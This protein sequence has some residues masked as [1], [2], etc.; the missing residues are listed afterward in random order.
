MFDVD[1]QGYNA[2]FSNDIS[3]LST[4]PDF[5]NQKGSLRKTGAGALTLSG[6]NTYQ[7]TTTVDGGTLRI[8]GTQ[9]TGDHIVNAGVLRVD[10]KIA[11]GVMTTVNTQG[12]LEGTGTT[13]SVLNKGTVAPGNSIG[14]LTV[15]G[16]YTATPGSTLAIEVDNNNRVD[17]LHVTG[18]TTFQS[19]AVVALQGEVF[20]QGIAYDFLEAG[21]TVAN[22]GLVFDSSL[23]F[24]TPRA[25]A[26]A[27]GLSFNVQRNS[28]AF[29]DFTSGHNQTAVANALDRLS[30]QPATG[31]ST[32]YDELLNGQ[33]TGFGAKMD[34]LS[35]EAYASVESALLTQSKLWTNAASRRMD[36]LFT[37]FSESQSPLWLS[38]QRQ[39][40]DLNGRSGTTD[41]RNTTNG[42]F[43]GG[44]A[45][46]GTGGHVGAAFGYHDG[47]VRVHDRQSHAKTESYTLAV[48][49]G[50]QWA[51]SN[52]HRLNW[53][54]SAAWTHHDVD[55]KRNGITVGKPQSLSASYR[56][57]QVQAYTELGYAMPVSTSTALQPFARLDWTQQRSA[58]FTESGGEAALHGKRQTNDVTSFNL[59]LRSYSEFALSHE[60]TARV[61]ASIGWRHAQ[62]DV[63]PTRTL[64]FDQLREARFTVNGAPISRNSLQLGLNGE[65]DVHKNASIGL[66]YSGEF[67]GGNTSNA[68]SLYLKVRF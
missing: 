60:S 32:I 40:T 35:G 6:S 31:L 13:G 52:G 62:G 27:S 17:A 19:G 53:H 18:N 14:T 10:G 30:N 36:T 33:G 34:Q 59:G 68:G 39:W 48:Y 3:D 58:S 28:V 26:S 24:L 44:D 4:D 20:R 9:N 41:V 43:I 54:S 11:P 67:G 25:T 51:L 29:S 16:N 63:T 8:T 15:N 61:S 55:M 42:L 2:T 12:V 23:L 66:N 46:I 21:G 49:G 7:G 5:L 45:R 57:Q 37:G 50:T 1:T 38:V 64:Q 65:V 56:S 47:K 22:Q